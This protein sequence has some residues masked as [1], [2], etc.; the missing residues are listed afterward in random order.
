M[1]LSGVVAAMYLMYS[2][3]DVG[4]LKNNYD[5]SDNDIRIRMPIL[6]TK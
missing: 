4:K 3:T 2:K 5:P 6:V 1:H